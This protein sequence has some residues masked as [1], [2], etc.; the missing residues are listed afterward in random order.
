LPCPPGQVGRV[1]V[2]ALHSFAMPLIRYD[3]GDL[4]SWG[5]PCGCGIT[6]PVIEK[7]WGRTRHQ[8]RLPDGGSLP[9]AF[10]GDELGLINAIREFRIYQYADNSLE[11]QVAVNSTLSEDD[12][13]AVT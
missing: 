1:L 9:M 8:V 7:L 10:I 13:A 11:I 6:L 12:E 2:T 4:A 5:E 3:I